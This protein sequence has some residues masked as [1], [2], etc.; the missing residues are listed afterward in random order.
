MYQ[1]KAGLFLKFFRAHHLGGHSAS[2]CDFS[3][4]SYLITPRFKVSTSVAWLTIA[5]ADGN[6][7]TANADHM[8][9]AV[10]VQHRHGHKRISIGA[11]PKQQ[12]VAKTIHK[13]SSL[14]QCA[15]NMH[16]A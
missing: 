15:E 16:P 11:S 3:G 9:L 13:T 14:Q 2:R 7:A 12:A 1:T 8:A 10:R 4:R 6:L 5:Y